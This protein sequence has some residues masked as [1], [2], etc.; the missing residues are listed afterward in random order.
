[1]AT[2]RRIP[3][4]FSHSYRR[5]DRD[6]NEFF[7]RTFD[8]HRFGFTVDPQSGPLSTCHLEMVMRR[9]AC[10]VAVATLRPEQRRYKCSPFIAYEYDL[11]VRAR[12]PRL[13]FVEKGVPAHLFPDSDER[14]VFDREE[15]DTYE[16][17]GQPIRRLLLQSQGYSSAGDHLL[18]EVGLALPDTPAYRQAA[19]LLTETLR[20]FGY[21]ASRVDLDATDPGRIPF[22][23]DR[24]D[25]VVIDVASPRVP[26]WLYPMMF[27]RFVPTLNLIHEAAGRGTGRSTPDLV[28]GESLRDATDSRQPV[29]WWTDPAK[30]AVA[31]ER[32]LERFDLPRQQ[33]RSLEEGIGY[34]RSTGREE[35]SI[36]LS[37]TGADNELSREVGRALKLQNFTFFHYVYNN[38]FPKGSK[39][40]D[41]LEEQLAATQVFVPLLSES[42]WRS[43]W[44]RL[45]L[46]TARRLSDQG[47]LTI[48]PYFLD[49]SSGDSVPEQG[50]DITDLPQ[51]DRVARIVGDMDRHLARR[52][53]ADDSGV[54][55]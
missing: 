36:F 6:V 13:V 14:L 54:R 19:P 21:T 29:L 53:A 2:A 40:Q 28:V 41:R 39:W 49:G 10:F 15:L 43:D 18:G 24:F 1:M 25:F 7:W 3:T 34:I 32:Q 38:T 37:T 20:K 9:S 23:L 26:R 55:P 11:A 5:E 31:V 8:A 44:C 48:I 22:Q 52:P 35:G 4:Y 12:K 17:F 33:F 50:T 47:Q 16:G 42:Y 46:E 45:E 30:L 27:G 51:H